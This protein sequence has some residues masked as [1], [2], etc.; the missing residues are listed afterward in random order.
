MATITLSG[1]INYDSESGITIVKTTPLATQASP[2]VVSRG[3]TI[4]FVFNQGGEAS[5]Y[6]FYFSGFDAGLWNDTSASPG[7][8]PGA[9]FSKTTNP[10]APVNAA[11]TV[12]T[13]DAQCGSGYPGYRALTLY[14][15]ITDGSDSVP[16]AFSLGPQVNN[17]SPTSVVA[18]W[19]VTVSGI[20]QG[21]SA[22]LSGNGYFTVNNGSQVTSATVYNG[23]NVWCFLVAPATFS[24]SASITLNIGGVTSVFSILTAASP[25]GGIVIDFPKTSGT[26]SLRDIVNFFGGTTGSPPTNLRSYFKGGT[27]VPD[28]TKNSSVPANGTINIRQFLGSGTSMFFTKLPYNQGRNTNTLGG[29]T[30]ASV[31]WTSG[32]PNNYDYDVGYGPGMRNSV[33]YRYTLS[34]INAPGGATGVTLSSNT[35]NPGAWSQ[36]NTAVTVSKSMG[37]ST[38]GRFTGE[39]TI[40]MMNIN[41]PNPIVTTTVRY[42]LNFFGP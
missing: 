40:H 38:E 8:A 27:Y 29:P 35:G 14:I 22:S 9:V 17:V 36:T 32:G 37:S 2:L 28:I 33:L 5:G 19:P 42:T 18:A 15:K 6:T 20:N 41:A 13:L 10:S 24:S 1:L 31:T 39:V 21:T 34:E 16:D 23:D 7:M 11:G 3:D 30:T 26:V 25:A 4:N 12:D